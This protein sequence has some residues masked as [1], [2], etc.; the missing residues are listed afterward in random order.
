MGVSS[1]RDLRLHLAHKDCSPF[2][3]RLWA[4]SPYMTEY[5]RAP[6]RIVDEAGRAR[7][8]LASKEATTDGAYNFLCENGDVDTY[9]Q[10]GLPGRDG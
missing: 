8:E 1:P 9:D 2:P 4:G 6:E 7:V 5:T 10:G 3:A